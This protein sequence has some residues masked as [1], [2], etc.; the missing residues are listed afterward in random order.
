MKKVLSATLL[1]ALSFSAGG[2]NPFEPDQ[3]VQLGVSALDAPSSVNAGT[4]FNIVLTVQTGGCLSF[5]RIDVVR[6]ET[7]V[8][9]TVWGK[10]ASKGRSGITCPQILRLEPHTYEVKP[11][12]SGPFSVFVDRG[13]LSP[14][15]ATVQVQ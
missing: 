10:D 7:S 12:Y 13:R 15:T 1:A 3:S 9:F 4:A 2:C 14:L 8:S 11:P 5:D 6:A